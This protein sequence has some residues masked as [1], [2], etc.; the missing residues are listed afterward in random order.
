MTDV[1]P[2]RHPTSADAETRAR[3]AFDAIQRDH[4]ESERELRSILRDSASPDTARMIA[5][6]GLG[7]LLHDAGQID[8]AMRVYP[9]AADLARQLGDDDSF[10]QIQMSWALCRQA[11]GDVAGAL[12]L[13]DDA[14]SHVHGTS[15]GRLVMQRGLV[16]MYLGRYDESGAE[17]DQ[18]LPLLREGDDRLAIARLLSNRGVVRSQTG[19]ID[20]ARADLLESQRLADELDQG[21]IAAGVLHNLGYLAGRT[22]DVPEALRLFALARERYVAKGS[23][24]RLMAALDSDECDVH[25]LAGLGRESM[26]IARRVLA[27]AV[28][29]GN[30][31]QVAESHLLVAKSAFLVGDHE[32]AAASATAA[33]ALFAAAD[34]EPWEALATYVEVRARAAGGDD[35]RQPDK[36]ISRLRDV[37]ATL[38]RLGWLAEASDVRV[39]LARLA[40]AAGRIDEARSDL[41]VAAKARHRGTPAQRAEA[42][43]ATAL[44]R[45][46]DG[47]RRG[48]KIAIGNG[49]RVIDRHRSTFGASELR[50]TSSVHGVALS[51]L[52]LRLALEHGRGAD[53]LAAAE[54]WRAGALLSTIGGA[55]APHP[56][57]AR[58]LAELHQIESRLRAQLL[59]TA[60][61]EQAE[62]AVARLRGGVEALERSVTRATRLAPGDPR[63]ISAR[64]DVAALRRRLG[65]RTLV[66]FVEVDDELCAVVV[67][68]TR[69]RLVRLGAIGTAV[70]AVDHLMFALRR[71]AM[72][73][74]DE[75]RAAT[76]LH[77][78]HIAA[79]DVNALLIHPLALTAGSSLVVI[80]PAGVAPVPWGLVAVRA[81]AGEITIAPSAAWWLA[82]ARPSMSGAGGVVLVAGPHLDGA[83]DEISRIAAAE[84][85][86]ATLTGADATTAAVLGAFSGADIVHVATH[87]TFRADNPMFSSLALADGRLLVHDLET[88][89]DPPRLVVL[90]SCHAGLTGVH[91]GGELIGT[92]T[93]LLS[94][95]VQAVIAPSIAIPDRATVSL[96]IDLHRALRGGASPPAALASAV[97]SAASSNDPLAVM[98][99]ASF[100]CIAASTVDVAAVD[101][102]AGAPTTL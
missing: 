35:Q 9:G 8:E 33:A 40:I 72:A 79:D 45:L 55:A 74:T 97:A 54:R 53:I 41:A 57:A 2:P 67:S 99:A 69:C 12:E 101:V 100:Q 27:D 50:A 77:R 22:H 70:V 47:N 3:A 76:V 39:L 34:R 58:E 102:S 98:A 62:T 21:L 91:P 18:A 84:P 46:A 7:R 20:G 64:L 60:S 4:A 38:Q 81:G 90:T 85:G 88:M 25:L 36:E 19:D 32:A 66:E 29:S 15:L 5:S 28:A 93:A 44:L 10:A 37:A 17:L 43:H 86:S 78:L 95:G 73:A 96:A 75:Q 87:G 42:W 16:L 23:P 30:T 59:E 92:A 63:S 13:L 31:L 65:H 94:V 56:D 6:W 14:E 61:G 49:L 68:S 11:S 51:Q 26:E 83:G 52:G 80:P 89:V 82:A 1:S 24:G 48:A 71:L